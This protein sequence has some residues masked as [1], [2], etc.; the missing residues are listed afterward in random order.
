VSS[1]RHLI[2]V[3]LETSGLTPGVHE[4]IEVA[5]INVDTEEV[6]SFV[7]YL[8]P[9]VLSN[10]DPDALRIN[11]YFERGV[12]KRAL[13][14][15]ATVQ[16]YQQLWDMLRGNT[17]AGANPRFDVSMLLQ[18]T[19]TPTEGEV[20]HHRL[21]DVSAYVAG[22]LHLYPAE[23]PGLAGCCEL[24]GV[25]NE[26]EHSALGDAKA[27]VECFRTLRTP[28]ADPRWVAHR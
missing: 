16:Q 15:D 26:G 1:K 25:I 12:Y 4:P 10:A 11:R 22:A 14:Y 2:V 3:D 7:P 13:T 19:G 5:A 17:L 20:W 18:A 23:L 24:L 27:T 6:V 9:N 28:A 21:A 8:D